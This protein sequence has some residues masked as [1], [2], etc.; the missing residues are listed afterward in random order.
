MRVSTTYIVQAEGDEEILVALVSRSRPEVADLLGPDVGASEWGALLGRKRHLQN[1][2]RRH[3]VVEGF[4]DSGDGG[5]QRWETELPLDLGSRIVADGTGRG[6]GS[7][8]G[9]RKG[10]E[11][12]L[13]EHGGQKKVGI[14]EIVGLVAPVRAREADAVMMRDNHVGFE[15]PSAFIDWADI[16]PSSDLYAMASSHFG[17]EQHHWTLSSSV[18]DTMRPDAIAIPGSHRLRQEE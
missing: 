3:D 7:P 6:G 10:D 12:R 1:G 13:A 9:F 8:E 18:Y 14:R 16:K 4:S 15:A 2:Q 17:P 5:D 11:S